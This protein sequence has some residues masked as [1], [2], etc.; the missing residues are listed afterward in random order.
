MS[1][2][3]EVN[4]RRVALGGLA[5]GA[6]WSIW[7]AVVNLWILAG[8]YEAAGEGGRLMIEP[9][10][11]FFLPAS[12]VMLFVLSGVIAWLYASVR[13]TR[14][15]GPLTALIVGFLVGFAAG[16]PVNFYVVSLIEVDKLFPLWWMLDLWL[17]AMLAALVAAWV[18]RD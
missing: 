10:Y 12:Y 9:R 1:E 7:N 16:F 18:Y 4:L 8:R 5:G 13:A 6:V 14:G 11:P 2:T 17:G 3:Y 15:P